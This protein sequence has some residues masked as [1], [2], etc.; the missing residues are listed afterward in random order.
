MSLDVAKIKLDFPIFTHAVRNGKPLIYLDSAATSHK[1]ASV[2]DTEARFYREEYGTVRRG[3]YQL[4]AIATER[5]EAAR[6]TV[7]RFINA[8]SPTEVIFTRG[9]TD[10][11]NLVARCFGETF[12]REGDEILLSEF[13]HHSN[14]VPWLML[15]QKV[16]VRLVYIKSTPDWRLDL[17]DF[18]REL[19]QRTKL[20][21]ITGMSNVLGT[22]NDINAITA[23]AHRVGAR[24][25]IDGAQ[26]VPHRRCD[27]QAI[28]CDFLAFS[29][30][31]MLGP[32]GVGVLYMTRELGEELPPYLGGGDMIEYVY[33]DDFTT[34]ELPWKFEAGTPNI[35]GVIAFAAA[36]D[37]INSIGLDKLA[38][39]EEEVTAYVLER[40][41]SA[42]GFT[43]YGPQSPEQRGAVFSFN[44]KD[45]HSHDVGSM[46][47]FDN[48]AIRAG[49]H[50]A[51]PLM[52]KLGVTSTVRASFF[53][54]NEKEEIDIVID[55]LRY[56]ERFLKNA[57]R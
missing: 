10:S 55:S 45:I 22:V 5:Y 47:D 21:A 42:D 7:A 28:G 11:I 9:A 40:L 24:V 43:L 15:Q 27:V 37:Y 13:E 51:Q 16:G 23:A 19:S 38:R 57:V 8:A 31:K 6:Q 26:L 56:A 46:L 36:I 1:P 14:I 12:F 17:E 18:E 30:H 54:Y 49:H 29:A 39:H 48:I 44:Y 52:G 34:T 25:L 2:I 33:Y 41:L 4:S 20:V 32:T 50:C 3:I 53:L 35:A